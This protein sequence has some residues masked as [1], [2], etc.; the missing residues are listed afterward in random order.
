M[1]NLRKKSCIADPEK[2]VYLPEKC[3]ILTKLSHI[4]QAMLELKSEV[5]DNEGKE[6][7]HFVRILR[8]GPDVK[9]KVT[10]NLKL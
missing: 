3:R 1:S 2:F 4:N 7:C 10:K 8:V 9:N 5:Y 6:E